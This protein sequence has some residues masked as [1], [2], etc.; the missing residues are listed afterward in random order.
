MNVETLGWSEE[1]RAS[2][3]ASI[4]PRSYERGNL[5]E[6]RDAWCVQ[7][8]QLSHVHMNVE[9]QMHVPIQRSYV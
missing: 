8:L 9:T 5:Q 3:I 6:R 7:A 2:F 1:T 4:E